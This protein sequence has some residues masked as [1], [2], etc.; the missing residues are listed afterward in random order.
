MGA[1]YKCKGAK[2]TKKKK[3]R[4]SAN[5]NSITAKKISD[6]DLKSCSVSIKATNVAVKLVTEAD[7]PS[8]TLPVPAS[9]SFPDC[10]HLKSICILFTASEHG[11]LFLSPQPS[12]MGVREA[13]GASR[14]LGRTS[15]CYFRRSN[16][17][18]KAAWEK[19][20][21]SKDS[22]QSGGCHLTASV[23]GFPLPIIK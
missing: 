10:V 17:L 4:G 21:G 5:Q 23:Q 1:I 20:S 22:S 18:L 12:E 6:V 8:A 11:R 14:E 3:K 7:W 16:L 19:P 15:L 13:R 9:A 2:P